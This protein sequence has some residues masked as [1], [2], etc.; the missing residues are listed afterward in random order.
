VSR[1]RENRMHGSMGGSWNRG[2][3]TATRTWA[4]GENAGAVRR[5]L[6]PFNVTAPAPYPTATPYERGKRQG[7]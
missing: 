2:V 7:H 5:G 1:V 6:P 4:P 3:A